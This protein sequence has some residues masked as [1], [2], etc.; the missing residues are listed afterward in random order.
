MDIGHPGR[1]AG[2]VQPRSASIAP[3]A[4]GTAAAMRVTPPWLGELRA[5]VGADNLL[6][7][8]PDLWVYSR[9]RSPY[10]TFQVRNSR[11][12]GTLPSAVACP[13]DAEQVAR[14]VRLACAH[15][16]PVLPYGCG[17]G[18]LGGALPVAHELVIDLKRLNR[19]VDIDTVNGTA[20]VE[21]GL[22]GAHFEAALN[23]RGY[24]SGHLPQSLHM[25]S[26]GGWAACRSAGQNSTRYGKIEDIVLGL[27]VVLPEGSTLDIRPVAHRAS[28]PALKDLFIGSEGTLGIITRL[29]LRIWPLP[30]VR[31]PLVLAF[32]T[33]DAGLGALRDIMQAELRP[34]IVRLYDETES[35]P[36]S[37]LQPPFDRRPLLAIL[38][39]CG[40]R[41]LAGLERD[42]S[43][44]IA[45]RHGALQAGEAPYHD[46]QKHRYVSFSVPWQSEGHYMDTVEV[47]AG[48]KGLAALHGSMKEAV[49]AVSRDFHFGAHWSHVYAEGACQ[50]MTIR[51]PPRPEEQ[52]LRELRA[53]WD[54]LQRLA[55]GAGG[56]ISHHHGVGLFRGPWMRAEH[57]AGLD[58]LQAIKDHLDPAGLFAPGKLGLRS[59]AKDGVAAP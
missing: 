41:R 8:V 31:H 54:A 45:D 32:P 44:E 38:E 2:M 51:L 1:P 58:L 56:S 4:L 23:A 22:N 49:M 13:D 16:T 25:S 50:Y 20:T 21:A 52:A 42:L 37:G 53:A 27:Q 24:T 59:P 46:W 39:F 18:V 29:T 35:P 14:V 55:I 33:L 30:E 12:P 11:V 57:G 3:A 17:S 7:D 10:A 43:L 15:G 6:V 36:R 40:S 19:I 34:A 5:I 26:V 28:G 48:W 9:D 47:T